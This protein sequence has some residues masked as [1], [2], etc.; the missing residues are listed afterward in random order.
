MRT[1]DRATLAAFADALIPEGGK[2]PGAGPTGV[3]A[4]TAVSGFINGIPRRQRTVVLLAL[5]VLEFATGSRRFSV[6]DAPARARRLERL[7]ANPVGRDL[8]LLLKALVSFGWARDGRVQDALG[9]RPRCELAAGAQPPGRDAPALDR[10]ALEPP[11]QRERCDVVVVGSGAGGASVARLL[12]EG[13]LDVIVA[14]EGELHDASTYTT[15]PLAA[16]GRLYRDGGLT[17]LEGRPAI[18]MPVGRCVG[19][20]TV[21]NSGTCV[22]TPGDVLRRWRDSQ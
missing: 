10:A 9:V 22:R 5:R 18:P 20:T 1:R 12:A 15:D 3:D 19:G 21:I 2:L 13:G 17:V 11:E 8:V 14:E 16:L 6:L 4:A 7:A